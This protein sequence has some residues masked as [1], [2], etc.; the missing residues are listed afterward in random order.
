MLNHHPTV[1]SQS[2]ARTNGIGQAHRRSTHLK[3]P[4]LANKLRRNLTTGSASL[5][6]RQ[7]MCVPSFPLLPN[8]I[9]LPYALPKLYDAS[10]LV[11]DGEYLWQYPRITPAAIRPNDVVETP[12]SDAAPPFAVPPT[13][14]DI[15]T[16]LTTYFRSPP[17][18]RCPEKS[19]WC[20]A[21]THSRSVTLLATG[22]VTPNGE[23]TTTNTPRH[24]A[25]SGI[26]SRHRQQRA[27]PDQVDR[28]RA[29]RQQRSRRSYL[30]HASDD[31]SS[32]S[33]DDQRVS[34]RPAV[35]VDSFTD[36]AHDDEVDDVA[37][38][39]SMP[40]SDSAYSDADELPDIGE[41]Q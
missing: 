28:T 1:G 12:R 23:T 26:A 21:A 5:L 29:R 25:D 2:R 4:A 11:A 18:N 39:T 37:N 7:R 20:L 31:S 30:F 40:T 41:R 36:Q 27:S 10:V 13:V 9:P 14:C 15:G 32:T 6:E 34:P 33:S 19:Q 3:T 38:S 17:N 35:V 22:A 8:R 24:I 16:P